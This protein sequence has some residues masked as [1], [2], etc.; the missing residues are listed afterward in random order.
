MNSSLH[1]LA[2][3]AVVSNHRQTTGFRRKLDLD[4]YLSHQKR[5]Q[6]EIQPQASKGSTAPARPPL[7]LGAQALPW[8]PWGPQCEQERIDKIEYENRQL[9]EKIASMYCGP[10]KVDCWNSYFS[11]SLNREM[12]NR[13]LMRITAENQAILRRLGNCKSHYDRRVS[14]MDWQNSRRYIR[15]TTRK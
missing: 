12:R 2:Y 11:R 4:H 6:I 9:C 5:L 1:Y 13:E 8:S 15:N 10:A 14:E 7:P 3:P